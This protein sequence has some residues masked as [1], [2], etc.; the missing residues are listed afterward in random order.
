MPKPGQMSNIANPE[1]SSDAGIRDAAQVGAGSRQTP[2]TAQTSMNPNR[3]K[4]AMRTGDYKADIEISGIEEGQGTRTQ[5]TRA[6]YALR[7]RIFN[8]T[9]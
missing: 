8:K 6:T 1:R 7:N 2:A 3:M 9:L 5:W 4:P